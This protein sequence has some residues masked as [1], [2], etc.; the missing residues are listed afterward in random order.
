MTSLKVL[1]RDADPAD[2]LEERAAQA[3]RRAVVAAATD[4]PAP[5]VVWTHALA[6]AAVLVLMLGT[7]ATVGRRFEP[8]PP[9]PAAAIAPAPAAGGERRQLHFATPGGTRIIWVFNS[10]FDTKEVMP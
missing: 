4:R 9:S 10:R 7:G 5:A 8:P 6:L 1:L 2:D 3:I